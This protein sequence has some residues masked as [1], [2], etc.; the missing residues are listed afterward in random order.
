MGT[1]V[2]TGGSNIMPDKFKF[3][4]KLV[5]SHDP[6][7][8]KPYQDTE[9]LEASF[10]LLWRDAPDWVRWAAQDADHT[11]HWFEHQPIA[12]LDQ[13]IWQPPSHYAWSRKKRITLG[14]YQLGD[15]LEWH[16]HILKFDSERPGSQDDNIIDLH[17]PGEDH[18]V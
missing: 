4:L 13:G 18:H 9:F 2:S 1:M 6:E 7:S 12:D 15:D 17:P 10:R 5:D 14:S 11:W 8:Y 16:H 3:K